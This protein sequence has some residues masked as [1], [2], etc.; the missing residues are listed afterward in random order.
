MFNEIKKSIK[1]AR[2]AAHLCPLTFRGRSSWW[3]KRLINAL[4]R[5][6]SR[7]FNHRVVSV[8]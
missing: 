3:V 7:L 8:G 2:R 4:C 5:V 6:R 1:D